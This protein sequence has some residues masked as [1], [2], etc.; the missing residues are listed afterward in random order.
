M[1]YHLGEPAEVVIVQADH[2]E[3]AELTAGD[4]PGVSVLVD[5]R[6]V[7]DAVGWDGVTRIVVG[8]AQR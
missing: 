5:G 4:L 7:T 2:P 3:Y 8:R 1:P 6:D